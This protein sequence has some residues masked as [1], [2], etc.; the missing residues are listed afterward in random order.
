MAEIVEVKKNIDMLPITSLLQHNNFGDNVIK[1]ILKIQNA[2]R[3][4][5]QVCS[6]VWKQRHWALLNMS[7]KITLG[8][9]I[10][11]GQ[12][13]SLVDKMFQRAQREAGR[14]IL[15]RRKDQIKSVIRLAK[16]IFYI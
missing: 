15:L 3:W 13:E 16:S 4:L 10:E 11:I 6:N 8:E 2:G 7:P 5:I 9:A 14:K 12:A 1:G